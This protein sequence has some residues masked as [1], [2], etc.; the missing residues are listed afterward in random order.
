VDP[1]PLLAGTLEMLR[2]VERA[3]MPVPIRG[4]LSAG[5]VI[6]LEGDDYIGHAINVAARLCDIAPGGAVYAA[7]SIIDAL[8]K[9]GCV[10]STQDTPIRGLERPLQV[11]RIGLR[12]LT[13]PVSTDPV[14]GI[15]LTREVAEECRHDAFGQEVWFCSDGCRDTWDRRP[16]PLAEGQGSLRTPLIGS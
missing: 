4:G 7:P 6:L 16:R 2:A 14:C 15:P 5:E 1:T 12:P 3:G 8:P 10:L 13:G 9:W 11:S